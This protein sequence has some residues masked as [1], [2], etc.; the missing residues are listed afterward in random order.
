MATTNAM[1]DLQHCSFSYATQ[2]SQSSQDSYI[3]SIYIVHSMSMHV[4][5]IT[6]LRKS[7]NSH[8]KSYLSTKKILSASL[9]L[10]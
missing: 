2:P 5:K 9:E 6:Q 1:S 8:N 10:S 4:L 7:N 3:H